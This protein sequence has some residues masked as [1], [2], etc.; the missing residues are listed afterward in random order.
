MIILERSNASAHSTLEISR[1]KS[2]SGR[3]VNSEEKPEVQFAADAKDA[4]SSKVNKKKGREKKT[5][6]RTAAQPAGQRQMRRREV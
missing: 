1:L 6:E 5:G 3:D 4:V 2:N